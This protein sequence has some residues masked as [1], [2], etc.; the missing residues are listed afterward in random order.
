MP[1]GHKSGVASS[2]SELEVEG[3][4][5]GELLGLV[6][7]DNAFEAECRDEVG[8][9]STVVLVLD[10]SI[11]VS[12]LVNLELAASGIVELVAHSKLGVYLLALPF[13]GEL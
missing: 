6:A 4:T 9:Q 3:E 1:V 5:D 11:N 2:S 8:S 7:L 12:V 13:V 10:D